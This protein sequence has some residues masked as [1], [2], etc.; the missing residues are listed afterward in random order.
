[1]KVGKFELTLSPRELVIVRTALIV[2]MSHII[3]AGDDELANTQRK[4]ANR[5]DGL[6]VYEYGKKMVDE[7]KAND[8]KYNMADYSRPFGGQR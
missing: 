4:I 6:L 1:M 7:L 8:A 3:N 5:I 2:A